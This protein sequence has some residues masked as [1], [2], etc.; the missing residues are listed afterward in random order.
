MTHKEYKCQKGFVQCGSHLSCLYDC[1]CARRLF[2]LCSDEACLWLQ[3]LTCWAAEAEAEQQQELDVSAMTLLEVE[4]QVLSRTERQTQRLA[5][6]QALA[7][8]IECLPHT[9]LLK[10]TTQVRI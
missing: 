6:L 9:L 2:K 7:A 4:Q 3:E 8:M 1:I 10:K 5:L